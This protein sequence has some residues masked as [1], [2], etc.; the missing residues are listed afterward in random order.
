MNTVLA[1]TAVHCKTEEEAFE[2]IKMLALDGRDW[3]DGDTLIEN[4]KWHER[5]EGSCYNVSSGGIQIGDFDFWKSCSFR[6][7]PLERYKDAIRHNSKADEPVDG[8]PEP[9]DSTIKLIKYLKEKE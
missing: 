4:N 1:N 3:A 2:L 5:K 6:I 9:E 7:L 8:R